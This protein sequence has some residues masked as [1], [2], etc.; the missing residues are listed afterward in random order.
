MLDIFKP[1]IPPSKEPIMPMF[2]GCCHHWTWHY[3][4]LMWGVETRTL[5][6]SNPGWGGNSSSSSVPISRPN[7]Y[8]D[9]QDTAQPP[10][11]GGGG[12]W[13]RI[14]REKY[15]QLMWTMSHKSTAISSCVSVW[16]EEAPSQL[17][18]VCVWQTCK[19]CST[20]LQKTLNILNIFVDK[21]PKCL[22]VC[23]YYQTMPTCLVCWL[24]RE[25][26]AADSGAD[27]GH[28][29]IRW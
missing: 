15:C 28:G 10:Q 14:F 21:H 17:E 11:W 27:V 23:L 12:E 13:M 19:Q 24:L 20:M 22:N 6:A 18:Q 5:A 1:S 29:E 26:C 9:G 16:S 8:C 2:W 25:M 4:C 3:C 7:E